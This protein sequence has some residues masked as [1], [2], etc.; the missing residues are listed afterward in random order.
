MDPTIRKPAEGRAVA[1][2]GDVIERLKPQV[3]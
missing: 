3:L 1:V 2:V